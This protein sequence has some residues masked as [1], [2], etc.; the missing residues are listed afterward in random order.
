[1]WYHKKKRFLDGINKCLKLS[2]EEFEVTLKKI[3]EI[4]KNSDDLSAILELEIKNT[5]VTKEESDLILKTIYYLV[6]R[7]NLFILSP[8]KLQSDLNDLGFSQEKAQILIQFYSEASRALITN[9]DMSSTGSTDEEVYWDIKT[10]LS[11]ALN[12]K[13]KIPKATIR[14]K[15]EAQEIS[16]ED[17]NHAEL[18]KL[19]DKIE[20]IQ[21]ELDNLNK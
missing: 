8:I 20:A 5:E 10:T 15:S 21:S 6:Q 1:M 7:F 11:D 12:Q 16:F 4:S 17:L 14:L 2:D 3:N 18:S 19:F 9:L 13:C